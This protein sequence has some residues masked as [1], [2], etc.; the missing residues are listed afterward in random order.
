MAGADTPRR[1]VTPGAQQYTSVL[2]SSM[3]IIGVAGLRGIFRGVHPGP[4]SIRYLWGST[5]RNGRPFARLK[6]PI[7]E[8]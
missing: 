4:G 3:A 1:A 7:A 5:G 8:R 6:I 2:R